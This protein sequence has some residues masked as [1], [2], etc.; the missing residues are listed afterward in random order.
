ML[1]RAVLAVLIFIALP[2]VPTTATADGKR[3]HHDDARR[4]VER[5]DIRPLAEIMG[6]VKSQLTGEVVSV[7]LEREGG[8]FIYELKTIEPDGRRREIYVDA[9]S[10]AILKSKEDD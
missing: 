3:L 9:R 4:H 5:G 10:G 6:Q 2:L 1:P 7:D 8:R